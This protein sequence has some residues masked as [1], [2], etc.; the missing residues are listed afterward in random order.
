MLAWSF[1]GFDPKRTLQASRRLPEAGFMVLSR[2]QWRAQHLLEGVLPHRRRPSISSTNVQLRRVRPAAIGGTM[3]HPATQLKKVY[4]KSQSR[5]VVP[6]RGPG[7][8]RRVAALKRCSSSSILS[9]FSSSCMIFDFFG[10]IVAAQ[11]VEHFADREFIY[12][13]HRNLLCATRRT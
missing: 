4:R 10:R 5:P 7:L 3:E 13:S 9:T 11:L 6:A 1:S 12:F 2:C 8:R